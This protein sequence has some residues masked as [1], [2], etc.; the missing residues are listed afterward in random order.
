M[1]EKY[2]PSEEEI[3]KAEN[4]MKELGLEERSKV[5][6]DA[7]EAGISSTKQKERDNVELL[8]EKKFKRSKNILFIVYPIILQ[9]MCLRE[10]IQ[11]KKGLM[12]T[13]QQ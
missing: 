1:S 2:K 6:Q 4:I 12:K 7:F 11:L 8:V 5:E 10:I 9:M 3:K 13:R